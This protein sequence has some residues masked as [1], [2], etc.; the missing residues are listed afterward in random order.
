[1]LNRIKSESLILLVD[2]VPINLQVLERLLAKNGYKTVSACDGVEAL[3]KAAELHPDL[4][5]M[6]IMMPRLN[7]IDACIEFKQT[8]FGKDV[9]VIFLTAL[10][11]TGSMVSGF[12][13]G[14]V[15]YVT[16]P[17]Q[18][19]ELIVRVRTHL[20]LRAAKLEL[21][22]HNQSLVEELEE[23]RQFEDELLAYEKELEQKVNIDELT[24]VANRRGMNQYLDEI[25]QLL[26]KDSSELAMIMCDIDFFKNYNDQYGH[27]QGD[28]CLKQ[29]A[30]AISHAKK[31]P[32][33]LV[34]RYGGEEFLVILPHASVKEAER[35]AKELRAEVE[36]LELKHEASSVS[37]HVT[38]SI[39]V[40]S[41]TPDGS[42]ETVDRLIAMADQALYLA[43]HAGRHR[44]V[45]YK[46]NT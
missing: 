19:L 42:R 26:P 3:E 24:Q 13:S 34:A 17:F 25:S 45:L 39:G 11:D 43:K 29:V 40:A 35:V 18:E 27:P 20:E 36:S 46:E 23:R 32:V 9:P 6:D 12:E 15:D 38:L 33:D 30:L 44:I 7:G 2:D 41:V 16:K 8:E 1:M 37:P 5:L 4:I 21:A 22:K 14:G 28:V 31:R 10:T